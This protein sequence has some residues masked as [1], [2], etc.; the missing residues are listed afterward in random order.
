MYVRTSA[1]WGAQACRSRHV[2]EHPTILRSLQDIRVTFRSA[3][4]AG[5]TAGRLMRSVHVRVGQAAPPSSGG[6]PLLGGA[7]ASGVR[8]R[9]F[10]RQVRV[11]S[12]QA[13]G[14]AWG[15]PLRKASSQ[16]PL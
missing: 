14:R 8:W 4:S 3:A 16:N 13:V 11:G 5:F 7:P 1:Q 2:R 10:L 12:I 9:W 6:S 15:S